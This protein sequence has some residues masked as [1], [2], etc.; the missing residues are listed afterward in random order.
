MAGYKRYRKDSEVSYSLGITLTFE[1]L[2]Y[3]KENATRV[4]VHSE[5]KDGD[6]LAHLRAICMEAGIELLFTDKIF[7][8]LSEKENCYVI[9]EF[10]KYAGHLSGQCSH[11]VLVN[12]SNA[13][14]LGTI[15]RSALGFG[16]GQMAVI[17]PAVDAFSPKVVRASMG[18]IFSV[19]FEYF[20][21]FSEYLGRF[22]E[23]E[24]YPF[25]L[26][27]KKRLY[28]VEPADWFSL[29]FGNEA[30][31]LPEEFL[32]VGTS[33]IIPHADRID[34]L[35]LPIAASIAMYEFSKHT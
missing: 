31:G 34:S 1:L 19:D 23:R 15:M 22:K 28:D 6:T 21:S 4:F 13:G 3:K 7:H 25:M 27:A 29:I 32:K 2:K 20:D 8:V 16:F 11:I 14:N 12:P 30:T 35:N 18:A 5:M 33:V 9:G 10:R 24:L 26:Q 17:R